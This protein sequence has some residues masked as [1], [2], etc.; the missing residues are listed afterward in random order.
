M[1]W[2][3]G[4]RVRPL[5]TEQRQQTAEVEDQ[6]SSLSTSSAVGMWSLVLGEHRGTCSSDR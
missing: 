1:L 5:G 2:P 6:V 3:W 4:H